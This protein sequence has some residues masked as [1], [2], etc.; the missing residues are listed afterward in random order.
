[1]ANLASEV[2]CWFTCERL[3]LMSAVHHCWYGVKLQL[4]HIC[5]LH[6][7]ETGCTIFNIGITRD[8]SGLV[9]FEA[10]PQEWK[11]SLL[12]LRPFVLCR[13][14]NC[15]NI[16]S[17]PLGQRSLFTATVKAS[18]STDFI[19]RRKGKINMVAT[20]SASFIPSQPVNGSLL[21]KGEVIKRK[22]KGCWNNCLRSN[23]LP[24]YNFIA[25]FRGDVMECVQ[26]FFFS[27]LVH[28]SGVIKVFV[29]NV[30][31]KCGSFHAG[32]IE[33]QRTMQGAHT[34]THTHPALR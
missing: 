24:Q 4:N 6:S 8:W 3:A 25:C 34:H 14:T 17:P 5:N 31:W 15:H 28:S 23:S 29:L 2:N 27:P 12:E 32:L 26:G 7:Q 1:M 9:W 19:N 20:W 11:N 16:A 13:I 10:T 21:S 22:L 30:A 18:S 33:S